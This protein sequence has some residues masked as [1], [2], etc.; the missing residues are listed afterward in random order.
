VLAHLP[1]SKE[2][3]CALR[4]IER[5]KAAADGKEKWR[6]RPLRV[7]AKAISLAQYTS[8]REDWATVPLDRGSKG[9]IWDNSPATDT[10]EK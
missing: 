8:L 10:G 1:V 9:K 5:G 4:G 2:T 7:F 6:A 3:E